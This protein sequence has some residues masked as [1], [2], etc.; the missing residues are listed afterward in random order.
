MGRG[1][2]RVLLVLPDVRERSLLMAE[3]ESRGVEVAAE[4]EASLV[5]KRIVWEESSPRA[6][7]W[8]SRLGPPGPAEREAFRSLAPQA[9]FV[10]VGRASVRVEE[11]RWPDGSIFVRRP[12]SVGELAN[13]VMEA[14]HPRDTL[15]TGKGDV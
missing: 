7:V 9:R 3:L 2:V 1:D 5:L 11:E 15:V 10:V 8:D 4:A 13:V 14:T 6:I 12:V